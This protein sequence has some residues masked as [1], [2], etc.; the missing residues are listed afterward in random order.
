MIEPE[1]LRLYREASKDKA[2]S[3]VSFCLESN[4]WLAGDAN[5]ALYQKSESDE[6][7]TQENISD[8]RILH[9]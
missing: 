8:V 6:E 4:N 3:N 9:C 7:W 2:I 5:G 1:K